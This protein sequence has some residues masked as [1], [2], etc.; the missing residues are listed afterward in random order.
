MSEITPSK[1]T[2]PQSEK[3]LPLRDKK[4]DK[5]DELAQAFSDYIAEDTCAPVASLSDTSETSK[6]LEPVIGK[7][8]TS[9]LSDSFELINEVVN[10]PLK[11]T[12]IKHESPKLINEVSSAILLAR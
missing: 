5:Q 9:K 1:I 8:E 12:S 2:P 11:E 6:T 3:K 10:M 7:P 4:A